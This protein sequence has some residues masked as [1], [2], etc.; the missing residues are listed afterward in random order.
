MGKDSEFKIFGV[1]DIGHRFYINRNSCITFAIPYKSLIS[2]IS[3]VSYGGKFNNPIIKFCGILQN[4]FRPRANQITAV[5]VL[6]YAVTAGFRGT[7][8]YRIIV[9][10][11]ITG[12]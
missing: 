6:V 10:I 12:C 4:P 1:G 3:K 2:P 11:K 9:I 7:G 5:T 8:V